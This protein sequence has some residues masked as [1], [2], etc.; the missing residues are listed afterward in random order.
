[1]PTT[2]HSPTPWTH[3]DDDR[4]NPTIYDAEGDQVL[5]VHAM[6]GNY[7]EPTGERI[8]ACVNACEPITD[9]SKLSV[10]IARLRGHAANERERPSGRGMPFYAGDLLDA[11]GV[12]S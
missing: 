3:R 10:L 12:R 5:Y 2:Q 8:V 4:G 11:L 7:N 1:M 9:L 6:D